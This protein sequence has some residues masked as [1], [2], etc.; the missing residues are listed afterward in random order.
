[1]SAPTRRN[2]PSQAPALGQAIP[3]APQTTKLTAESDAD[4]RLRDRG[5]ISPPRK[6]MYSS[7]GAGGMKR[8]GSN[9]RAGT[10]GGLRKREWWILGAITLLGTGVRFYRLGWPTSVV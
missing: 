5:D 9:M 7:G 6:P 3:L 1:M 10:I 4:T 8:R 2:V